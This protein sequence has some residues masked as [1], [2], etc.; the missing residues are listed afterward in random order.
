MTKLDEYIKREFEESIAQAF[1]ELQTKEDFSKFFEE[2]VLNHQNRYFGW[3][4]HNSNEVGSVY[5]M[6]IRDPERMDQVN[7]FED[8]LFGIILD[9]ELFSQR[10]EF[11]VLNYGES[12]V[13]KM[14]PFPTI[15]YGESLPS[16]NRKAG[17]WAP[18]I[19]P[20]IRIDDI[21][22]GTIAR[23]DGDDP[24]NEFAQRTY[25]HQNFLLHLLAT[26]Q[27]P[28]VPGKKFWDRIPEND[29]YLELKYRLAKQEGPEVADK[30]LPAM[31]RYHFDG[32][33]RFPDKDPKS[34]IALFLHFQSHVHDED[35]YSKFLDDPENEYHAKFQEN[36][37]GN[38]PR[39]TDSRYIFDDGKVLMLTDFE[40]DNGRASVQYL[41][42]E[43]DKLIRAPAVVDLERG[44]LLEGP[45]DYADIL[46]KLTQDF[47]NFVTGYK[48]ELTRV[49]RLAAPPP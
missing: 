30:L 6:L 18:R 16:P 38:L 13:Q 40:R 17:L 7:A 19:M 1:K 11:S 25:Q 31:V 32:K 20:A 46:V 33:Q 28:E 44:K 41:L 2:V 49:K 26:S 4:G 36:L 42:V 48:R 8:A 15:I 3:E 24:I 35:V 45:Q 10:V 39:K 23:Q 9:E 37:P 43:N 27:T 14:T 22:N 47:G 34:R 12:L 5:Q 21:V 29:S